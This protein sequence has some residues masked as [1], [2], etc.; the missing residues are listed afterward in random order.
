MTNQPTHSSGFTN[1]VSG[2]KQDV[3]EV[4]INH[5]EQLLAN[6]A[7]FTLI[8]VRETEEWDNGYIPNAIHISKGILERD[9]EKAVPNKNTKLVLYCG[10][11]S[12]SLISADNL[13]K[14]GYTDV[15]SM[16]GG[17]RG[18]VSAGLPLIED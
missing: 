9:I 15:S 3:P 8:D 18:W 5:V 17:I 7:D 10:G 1:L 16:T 13:L 2:L 4:D 11:G 14:M 12:R 6:Q